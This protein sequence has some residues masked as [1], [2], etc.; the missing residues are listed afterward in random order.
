VSVKYYRINVI[1]ILRK[2][3]KIR[4]TRDDE[5]RNIEGK[6]EGREGENKKCVLFN[7]SGARTCHFSFWWIRY[8]MEFTCLQKSTSVIG[9]LSETE[10]NK[11]FITALVI[12]RTF[13]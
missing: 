8:V 1:L 10:N 2:G 4:L 5:G 6:N 9:N 7:S 13:L 11:I 3:V 12:R